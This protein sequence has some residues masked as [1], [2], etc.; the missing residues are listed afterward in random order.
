M[1]ERLYLEPL[2]LML[3]QR[4]G[5]ACESPTLSLPKIA[6]RH[7]WLD[8]FK[9]AQLKLVLVCKRA[10]KAAFEACGVHT[11]A[12]VELNTI[13]FETWWVPFWVPL[14][15]TPPFTQQ[16][17]VWGGTLQGNT[18]PE[19]CFQPSASAPH[20]DTSPPP[21]PLPPPSPPT[22]GGGGQSGSGSTAATVTSSTGSSGPNQ[23]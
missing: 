6:R 1:F 23:T 21:P 3:G 15:R 20:D 5:N 14:P 7:H 13:A 19:K 4:E 17:A 2:P 11:E 18:A 22:A 12:W 9:I 10:M 8:R 16:W